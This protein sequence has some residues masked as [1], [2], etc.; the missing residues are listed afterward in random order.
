MTDTWKS[1]F[2]GTIESRSVEVEVYDEGGYR[3]HTTQGEDNSG[4]V[5]V[6]QS[7]TTIVSPTEKGREITID[8]ETVDELRKELIAEGFSE[9]AANEIV[10]K[11]HA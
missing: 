8:G 3:V 2:K 6:D 5:Q 7:S 4:F 11:I 9:N 1:I 10:G